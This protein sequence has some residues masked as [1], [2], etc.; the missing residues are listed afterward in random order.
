MSVGP[1]EP[2]SRSQFFFFTAI[3]VIAGGIYI[4]PQAVLSD[5]G[6]DAPWS[7]L[8]SISL[9]FAIVWWQ[10]SWPAGL[11]GNSALAR[12]RWIWGW[13]RWPLYFGTIM[14]YLILD[15]AL[16]SLFSHLLHMEFYPM[17]PIS[18][19]T[20]TTLGMVG[21][22]AAKS[23]SHF[24]RNVHWWFPFVLGAFVLLVLM[25]LGSFHQWAAL[26]PSGLLA[27]TP[28]LKGVVSTLF[29][30]VQGDLIVT[31]GI[32]VRETSWHE[33]RRLAFAA[34]AVQSFVVVTT[35]MVVVGTLG[36]TVAKM[37]E[38]PAIYVFSNLTVPTLFISKPGLFIIIVWVIALILNI[39][40]HVSCLAIN[41]QDG[42]GLSNRGRMVTVWVLV[43]ALMLIALNISTP[44][45]GRAIVLHIVD[46][47]TL[48][49]TDPAILLSALLAFGWRRRQKRH[50]SSSFSPLKP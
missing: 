24:A 36:P 26:R 3:S 50:P 44:I 37:L 1:V 19:F 49:V 21:W 14:S 39:A 45:V 12:M 20:V 33:I 46:P 43:A 18:L 22:L 25:A 31:M 5:A 40:S 32:H 9:A 4:W 38:W 29:L 17:S 23:L 28:I 16:T 13:L 47:L 42:L 10:T 48:T 41:I 15:G 27:V 2:M 34:I 35:Y 30:W 8:L 7:L 11:H 6:M